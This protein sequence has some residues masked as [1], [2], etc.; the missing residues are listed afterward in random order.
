MFCLIMVSY[1]KVHSARSVSSLGEV[2]VNKYLLC[3][4]VCYGSG[5]AGYFDLGQI[6][7]YLIRLE[8]LL[9]RHYLGLVRFT[10]ATLHRECRALKM[11]CCCGHGVG[12]L[13]QQ[14]AKR[15]EAELLSAYCEH[16]FGRYLRNSR[17]YPHSTCRDDSFK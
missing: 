4:Y 2:Q 1:Q 14:N 9:I 5:K 13:I 12:E 10:F 17:T 6:F 16:E 11:S 8:G 15:F 7:A 3:R